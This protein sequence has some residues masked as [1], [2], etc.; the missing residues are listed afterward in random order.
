MGPVVAAV[1]AYLVYVGVVLALWRAGKVDYTRI[2]ESTGTIRRGLLVPVGVGL[3]VPLAAITILGWWGDVLTQ[4]RASASWV[5]VVPVLFGVTALIGVGSMDWRSPGRA[6]VPL[7]AVGVLLVGAAEELVARGLLVVGPQRAGWSMLGVFLL[8]TLLFSLLHAINGF[9]GLP[10]SAVPVQLLT[11]L[12][13][14]TVL[15]VC[16]FATGSLV[17]CMLLHALWDFATLCLAATGRTAKPVYL[18]A[19]LVTYVAGIAAAIPVITG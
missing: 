15:F 7:I 14:G 1:V 17:V 18:A 4:P 13:G 6:K 3:I 8:S 10:W 19:G 11:T 16:L 2:A 5:L 9:V 12:L